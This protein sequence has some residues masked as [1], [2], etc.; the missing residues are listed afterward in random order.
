MCRYQLRNAQ[1]CEHNFG[2]SYDTF[3]VTVIP[4]K[5]V[6]KY[7]SAFRFFS[8]FPKIKLP[9][10][11]RKFMFY[12]TE[13]R[14]PALQYFSFQNFESGPIAVFILGKISICKS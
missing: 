3:I 1:T 2:Y 9:P 5:I 8:G 4:K 12:S 11:I 14:A 7:F 13:P 6:P 10:E